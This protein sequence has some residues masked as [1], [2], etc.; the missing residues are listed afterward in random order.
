[1]SWHLMPLA[2]KFVLPNYKNNTIDYLLYT[3]FLFDSMPLMA[4]SISNSIFRQHVFHIKLEPNILSFVTVT[5]TI[6]D[7]ILN[8]LLE[9]SLKRNQSL[10]LCINS[11]LTGW[12]SIEKYCLTILWINSNLVKHYVSLVSMHTIRIIIKSPKQVL[13][14]MSKCHST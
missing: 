8:F 4:T 13:L 7:Y 14:E 5:Y 12:C 11:S 2:Y 9:F 3:I 10:Q 6:I 1:M